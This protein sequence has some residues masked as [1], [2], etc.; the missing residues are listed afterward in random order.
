LLSDT[1]TQKCFGEL[2]LALNDFN[3]TPFGKDKA[4][5]IKCPVLIYHGEK[6]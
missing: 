5:D 6:A 3:I 1:L 4:K 2:L